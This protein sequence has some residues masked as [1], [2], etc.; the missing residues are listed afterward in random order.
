[1]GSGLD[2]PNLCVSLNEAVCLDQTFPGYSWEW[3]PSG[4]VCV[5]P[6]TPRPSQKPVKALPEDGLTPRPTANPPL[7][8]FPTPRPTPRP[9]T[10]GNTPYPTPEAIIIDPGT[11]PPSPFVPESC[12][13]C[14]ADAPC[15]ERPNWVRAVGS[16]VANTCTAKPRGECVTGGSPEWRR[17]WCGPPGGT[18]PIS[19]CADDPG[20]SK[21]GE[22][23]KTCAA[24]VAANPARCSVKDADA[25]YAFEGC[26][27]TCG[28][29]ARCEDDGGWHKAG[30][31]SKNCNIPAPLRK[32]PLRD[33][34]RG[35]W[36]SLRL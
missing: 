16:P 27:A 30:D 33:A 3:C 29:C 21:R 14:P 13:D 26:K 32:P 12:A 15:F 17:E 18:T 4:A 34:R 36:L 7:A 31:P 9:T 2:E 19:L 8:K 1:V 25:V 28:A 22:P 6:C 10:P 11:R 23:G 24:W 20:W 35:T 5:A